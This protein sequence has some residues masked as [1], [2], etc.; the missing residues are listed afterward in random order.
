V[1]FRDRDHRLMTE[2]TDYVDFVRR[3]AEKSQKSPTAIRSAVDAA[4]YAVKALHVSL[5]KSHL[6]LADLTDSLLE[7][8]RNQWLQN[9]KR[10]S[11]SRGELRAKQTT[12][13]KL[14][15]VYTYLN[16]CQE[17]GRVPSDT[18]GWTGCY[19]KSSLPSVGRSEVPA[20]Y[21]DTH[22]HPLVYSRIGEKSRRGRR[23]H[24]ATEQQIADLEMWLYEN[25]NR[26]AAQ[27]DQLIVRI[28]DV[29]A[30]RK[31]TVLGLTIDDFSDERISEAERRNAG[32]FHVEPAIQKGGN[33]L[34]FSLSWPLTYRIVHYINDETGRADLMKNAQATEAVARRH[35]FLNCKTGKPLTPAGT[36]SRLS[37][38][39]KAVGF[40]L[41]AGLHSIRRGTAKRTVRAEIEFRQRNGLSTAVEDITDA[42]S[43]K[44][45]HTS[46]FSQR[47]YL[48]V[49]SDKRLLSVEEQ[50]IAQVDEEKATN[51]ALA[52]QVAR[53]QEQLSNPQAR[54]P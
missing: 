12:N 48:E 43:E 35:I 42:V 31:G 38:A 9:T 7:K 49:L 4:L 47:S 54:H 50:L 6:E 28:V 10:K 11:H 46:R 23:Q 29:I 20:V 5:S 8:Y 16:W 39:F 33:A 51:A 17:T 37:F 15:N 22:K 21:T 40:P 24:W 45:G 19:V 26:H 13:V 18:I 36:S 1:A 32:V 30:W 53:L 25:E 44:L 34:T 52:A 14:R 3:N 2:P 27:R 41:G